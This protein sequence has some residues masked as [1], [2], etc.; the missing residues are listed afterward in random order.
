A[1]SIIPPQLGA[2]DMAFRRLNALS[3]WLL[4]ASGIILYSTFAV[5]QLPAA[6]WTSYV[7]LATLPYSPN[8]GVDL[9][10][11]ELT[12]VG[13]SSIFGALNMIVTIFSLRAPGMPF[14]R[15]TLFTL[16][17]LGTSFLL[18]P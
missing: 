2:R 12:V 18:G 7:P 14:F 16:S 1:N 15:I 11:L 9:W 6:G 17:V 4:L 13:F 5:A 10:I 3:Y 8:H